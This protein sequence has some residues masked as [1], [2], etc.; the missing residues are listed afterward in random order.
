MLARNRNRKIGFVQFDVERFKL[1]NEN[2]GSEAGDELLQFLND[3]L[4]L[5]CNSEQPII[6]PFEMQCLG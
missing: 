6:L 2:L 5:I 1:I 4:G 3:S